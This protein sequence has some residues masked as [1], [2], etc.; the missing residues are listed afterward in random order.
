MESVRHNYGV[1][2]HIDELTGLDACFQCYHKHI[3]LSAIFL[4]STWL[5]LD[6][7]LVNQ[8]LFNLDRVKMFYN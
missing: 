7:Y 3:L 8:L 4:I 2:F 6:A 1:S 5:L